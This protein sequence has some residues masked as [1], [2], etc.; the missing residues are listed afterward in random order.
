MVLGEPLRGYRGLISS[1]PGGLF[2]PS[3]SVGAGLGQLAVTLL[4][5]M[6][7]QVI[8]LVAM[9][10]YFCGVVQRPITAAVIM[11]E[12]TGAHFVTLPL[13]VATVLAYVIDETYASARGAI[14]AEFR[15]SQKVLRLFERAVLDRDAARDARAAAPPP[16]ESDAR[17]SR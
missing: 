11:V 17:L 6:N 13:L 16:A 3:L 4:P 1:I 9:S 7:R 5:E 12:M 8:I 14:L 15:G 2:T 10:A